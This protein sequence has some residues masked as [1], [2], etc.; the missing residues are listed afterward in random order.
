MDIDISKVKRH[1]HIQP[2]I[3]GEFK[4]Q[5]NENDNRLLNDVQETIKNTSKMCFKKCI[6]LDSPAF[7]D[8][9]QKCIKDCTLGV[10]SNLEYMMEKFDKV[11][12]K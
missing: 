10:I 3:H 5:P 8:S 11:P 4:A 12:P 7:L 6:N 1:F 9:E 2:D